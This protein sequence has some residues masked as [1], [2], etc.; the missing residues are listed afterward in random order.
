M[1]HAS[2]LAWSKATFA[3]IGTFLVA[4]LTGAAA[5]DELNLWA[6][7]VA[8]ACAAFAVAPTSPRF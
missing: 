8:G 3:V 1:K 6:E 5:A 7:P 4:G 2:M